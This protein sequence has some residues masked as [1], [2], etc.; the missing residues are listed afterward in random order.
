MYAG[1]TIF[2]AGCTALVSPAREPLYRGKTMNFSH[3]AD[4]GADVPELEVLVIQYS[5]KV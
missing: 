5:V 4:G 3:A 2:F 1:I